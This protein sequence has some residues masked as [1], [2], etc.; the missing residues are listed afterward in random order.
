MT[1]RC[2][3]PYD[4]RHDGHSRSA[5]ARRHA[6]SAHGLQAPRSPPASARSSTSS[7]SRCATAGYP[8]SVREIGE[9]IGLTSPSTVHS[10]LNT[11]QRLGYLRRDPTK[12]RAIEVRWDP[13]SGRRHGAPAGAPRAARRRRRRRH[14]RAGRGERR[15]AAAR[16]P[17]DFTGEGELF[18]LRVRGD[19]M[20]D[21]GILDGDF[22]IAVQQP[23][24]NNGDIVVA[25]IPGGE[26]TVK[27]FSKTR[28]QG[29][30][31][32]GQ[33]DDGADGLRR[34]RRRALRPGRHRHAPALTPRPPPCGG[35][36]GGGAVAA[37]RPAG[38]RRRRRRRAA[39]ARRTA[40]A[41]AG[42]RTAGRSAAAGGASCGH[43]RRRAGRRRG[44][45]GAGGAAR[46][47]AARRRARGRPSS[48]A[49]APTRIAVTPLDGSRPTRTIDVG[50]RR[51]RRSARSRRR[52]RSRPCGTPLPAAPARS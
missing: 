41:P 29:H 9:A 42:W 18:M 27:T 36:G 16:C 4:E 43:C 51:R 46:A 45:P 35:G 8:P 14:R 21:A 12:P 47:P 19:S 26:A 15:G 32:P 30:A 49:T 24:A 39:A 10:H 20:I 44:A 1:C 50:R 28:R 25:G 38:D 3:R 48:T 23:T 13:N 33:L 40:A 11:L 31:D 2:E 17:A 7:S 22:V 6:Q 37:R 52:R 5:T 34:G